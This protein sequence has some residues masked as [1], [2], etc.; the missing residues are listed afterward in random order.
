MS[1]QP[2]KTST[3]A[4]SGIVRLDASKLQ[5]EEDE[6][7]REE[8]EI[9][10]EEKKIEAHT[11]TIQT[12]GWG[13][14]AIGVLVSI[15]GLAWFFLGDWDNPHELGDFLG[16]TVASCWGL[17]GL[18]FIY[19]AFL[20]QCRQALLQRLDVKNNRFEVKQ[21]RLELQTQNEMMQQQIFEQTFF[22]LLRSYNDIVNSMSNMHR[23]KNNQ[24]NEEETVLSCSMSD[25]NLNAS[26]ALTSIRPS[27]FILV[28]SLTTGPTWST[29]S[30]TSPK[31]SN[32]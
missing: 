30:D 7:A 3:N 18:M 2:A 13:L 29:I 1:N 19:V 22:Q 6:L 23:Q 28:F 16:G 32:T 11:K 8:C 10:A 31:L 14:V 4:A 12:I 27:N 9:L 17:A 21:T 25:S 5:E 20:G 26:Q 15:P 24:R